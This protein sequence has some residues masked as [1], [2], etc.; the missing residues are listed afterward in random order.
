[1][2]GC[3]ASDRVSEVN[4]PA[5]VQNCCGGPTYRRWALERNP[6]RA[7]VGVGDCELGGAPE[8]DVRLLRG[9]GVLGCGG[10]AWPRRRNKLCSGGA[11]RGGGAGMLW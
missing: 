4:A 5:V 7:G 10:A 2:S 11:K 1:M 3:E 8:V 9:S 6:T